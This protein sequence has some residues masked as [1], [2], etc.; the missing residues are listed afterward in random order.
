MTTGNKLSF[1][2]L[3][4]YAMSKKQEV[5]ADAMKSIEKQFGKGALI[6]MGDNANAAQVETV[7]S[8]SY[9][10]DIVLGG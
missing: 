4:L 10:L 9:L 3:L 5:I 1:I 8:G 2:S 6:K 7:H